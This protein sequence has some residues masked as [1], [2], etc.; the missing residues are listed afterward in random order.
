[1]STP[2]ETIAAIATPPGQGGVGIIRIS[3]PRALVVAEAMAG[4]QP[5]AGRSLY[6]RF[7]DA[8]GE[9]IDDGL[10]LAFRA[11]A[12]FTGEDVA[13]LQVHGG[14]QLLNRL[15]RVLCQEQ[16]LRQAR[17][18]EFSERAFHNGKL[19]LAQAEAIAD[20]IAAGSEQAA[21]A[22]RRS[23]TG[24]FSARCNGLH[25]QL[26]DLRMR[27][28]AAIDFP[29]EDID[30]LS[31]PDLRERWRSLHVEHSELLAETR[32]GVRLNQGLCVVLAGAPNAGK[33]SLINSLSQRDLA[34][35]T[36]VPGTTRDLLQ[37]QLTLHGVPVTVIDTAG[38]RDSEDP[39]ER[40]GVRRARAAIAQADYLLHVQAPDVPNE[41]IP[42]TGAR[43]I[44]VHN[45]C[46][47]SG[48][49]AGWA[50]GART[51]IHLSARTGEGLPALI[52]ELAGAEAGGDSEFSAR[53]R[54]LDAL[55][56]CGRHLQ[57][58]GE[59]LQVGAGDLAAEELRLAQHALGEI[60][61]QVHSDDL[62]GR[63]FSSFC[64]GK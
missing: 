43:V 59:Q 48:Q 47:L 58:A 11:P 27:L 26:A 33:S 46:D 24:V 49:P 29:E 17:P 61:G 18:G 7:R 36:A 23:L 4:R 42:D 2:I 3:G 34:I 22:A 62:L 8:Q 53:Q 10:L 32:H 57:H 54:H 30:F 45:K 6:C 41:R 31:D 12:S 56:C 37:A 55:Q 39:V 21:R 15:L 13:E 5:Q 19:D 28:E 52:D 14:P 40:E 51:A 44:T 50:D 25:E 60:T 64:I 38:L 63:I 1:M 9:V 35:V 20:L 16:G